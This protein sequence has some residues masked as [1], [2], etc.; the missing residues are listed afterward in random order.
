MSSFDRDDLW[1]WVHGEEDDPAIA[2][3]IAE[4]VASDPELA[5]EVAEMRALVAGLDDAATCAADEPSRESE[6]PER[7]GT[8][9]ILRRLG[10][11]GM[12]VVFEAE[13]QQ[14]KRHVALKVIRGAARYDPITVGLFQREVQAL[15]QLEHPSIAQ[16]FEAGQAEDGSHFLV[17]ELVSG[18]TLD[19]YAMGGGR[20][21]LDLRGRLRLMLA[22]CRA[23]SHAHQRG[24]IRRDLKPANILVTTESVPK[25]L[26]FGLARLAEAEA[27]QPA[28]LSQPGQAM[29][30]LAYM[31]P[32]QA[33]GD[34][35]RID[36]R[37]DVY[38]LGAIL[39]ELVTGVLP[40]DV[41][42]GSFLKI[43]QRITSETVAAPSVHN[44]RL[45]REVDAIVLKA[46]APELDRRYASA[47][48]L[49]D[50]IERYLTNFPI[51]AR[52]PSAWYHAQLFVKRNRTAV[53]LLTALFISITGAAIGL[54]ILS[55]K[56]QQQRDQAIQERDNARES[57]QALGGF[58]AS[59]NAWKGG[60]AEMPVAE[61]LREESQ[62]ITRE[63]RN[64]ETEI[65]LR[66]ALADTYRAV[67]EFAAARNERERVLARQRAQ[68]PTPRLEIARNLV[69]LG[70]LCYE[71][72][73]VDSSKDYLNEAL[74]L[75]EELVTPPDAVFAQALNLR[76][77]IARRE[78]DLDRAEELLSAA[79]QQRRT[80][81]AAS[82]RDT[83]NEAAANAHNA[84]AQTINNRAGVAMDRGKVARGAGD[85]AAA[86]Q[87]FSLARKL[88][89][90]AL[91]LRET[92]LSPEHPEVAKMCN[93]LAL[94]LWLQGDLPAAEKYLRRAVSV[95]QASVGEE[96]HF[97]A[98]A[99]FNLA[100]LL[101]DM[102]QREAALVEAEQAAA[103][104]AKL[105]PADHPRYVATLELLKQLKP[106][107]E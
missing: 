40:H 23:I 37:T 94:A 58:V 27:N 5:S 102:G 81:A 42:S 105:F 86:E 53:L 10:A 1:A 12:G 107:A 32:E 75:L 67:S 69:E 36:L 34:K 104:Q 103:I 101:N 97:T 89:E 106:E 26:D 43:V 76:G 80:I 4:A 77:V 13:Q 55:V 54:G 68:A 18:L 66:L 78:G 60:S 45:P 74:P 71:S 65:F 98:G 39:Y 29:G 47:A 9:R 93:N 72:G 17:M 44:P 99:R 14:P 48:E 50:D 85:D 8:Y 83:N 41:G 92:W 73:D 91:R 16:I 19:A 46:L 22:V 90:E 82:L 88:Y 64:P 87:A 51:K 3:A 21:V 79:L 28:Q 95:A 38:S 11:G 49:A 33:L 24:V 61:A 100:R 31:S 63:V 57:L 35:E 6:L 25:I 20:E 56:Y 7:I 84:V 96:H 59:A 70:D 62:R 2:A 52:R 30:T 15:A